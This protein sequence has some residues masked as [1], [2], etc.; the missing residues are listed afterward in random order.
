MNDSG[1]WVVGRLSGFNERET[2]K[3]WTVILT[4]NSV[5]GLLTVLVCSRLFPFV[6]P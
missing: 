2:L 5:V 3:T 1:F 4:F 6:G